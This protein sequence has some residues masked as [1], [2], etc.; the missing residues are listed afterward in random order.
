L[1]LHIFDLESGSSAFSEALN[2][3][4]EPRAVVILG[5]IGGDPDIE[6]R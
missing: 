6:L 2:R 4:M 1:I 3:E 5:M